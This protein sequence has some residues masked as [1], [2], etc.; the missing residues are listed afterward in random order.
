MLKVGFEDRA[1]LDAYKANTEHHACSAFIR[2][3][4]RLDGI[5]IDIEI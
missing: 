3:V 1:A 2:S 5:V 4:G